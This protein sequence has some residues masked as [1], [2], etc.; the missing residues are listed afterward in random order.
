MGLLDERLV[1]LNAE[2]ETA[3]DCIR[4]AGNLFYQYDY[5]Q[6]GYADAVVEREKEYPTGLP[7]KGISIAIPHTNNTL[8]NK[9]AVGVIIPKKPISFLMMGTKDNKLQCEV[10]LPL[11]V[12]DSEMQLAMLKKMM[13]IIQDAELLIKIRDARNKNEILGY[14]S[15]LEA[16]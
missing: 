11:V 8:V 6:E 10:I 15:P 13:K 5:V 14:L 9:P 1:V 7:G 2:V 12:K 4:L 16:I 3:E